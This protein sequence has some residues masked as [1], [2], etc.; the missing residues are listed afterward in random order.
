M[1]KTEK[2][3]YY[4]EIRESEEDMDDDVDDVEYHPPKKVEVSFVR[5]HESLNL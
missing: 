3:I 2:K 4:E 1:R 5:S